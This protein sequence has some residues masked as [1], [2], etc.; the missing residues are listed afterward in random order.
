M[1][2]YFKDRPLHITAQLEEW[3]QVAATVLNLG[4]IHDV[5]LNSS[6]HFQNILPTTAAEVLALNVPSDHP[7]NCLSNLLHWCLQPKRDQPSCSKNVQDDWVYFILRKNNFWLTFYVTRG[8]VHFES[9]HVDIFDLQ[10]YVRSHSSLP[11]MRLWTS[12]CSCVIQSCYGFVFFV[13]DC[14]QKI[15]HWTK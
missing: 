9:L 15:N 4:V 1:Q 2:L 14:G 10:W 13:H 11:E 8:N 6:I 12:E 7:C 3:Y 5:T